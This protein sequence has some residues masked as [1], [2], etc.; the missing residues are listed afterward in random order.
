MELIYILLIFFLLMVPLIITKHKLNIILLDFT[1]P[2][3]LFLFI[4]LFIFVIY[5]FKYY[6]NDLRIITATKRAIVAF[7]IAYLAHIDLPHGAFILVFLLTYYFDRNFND[8]DDIF[9]G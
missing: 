8:R 3:Y 4:I 6:N 2:I 7:I 1:D 5:L 9:T